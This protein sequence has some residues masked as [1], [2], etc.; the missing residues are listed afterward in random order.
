MF[1]REVC[2]QIRGQRIRKV[3]NRARK[4]AECCYLSC[5]LLTASFLALDPED[6][7]NT[8]FRNSINLTILHVITFQKIVSFIVKAVETTLKDE[9]INVR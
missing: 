3:S 1:R 9:E 6:G 7:N 2:L 8:I 4:Q 5:F